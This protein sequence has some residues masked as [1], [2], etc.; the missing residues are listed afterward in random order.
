MSICY[1][2]NTTILTTPGL[3]YDSR[4]ITVEEARRYVA[5]RPMVS[6]V[7]HAATAAIAS[8]LL[9]VDVPES[10]AAIAMAVGDIAVCVKLRG[11][12]LEGV[13]LTREEVEGI[14]YDLV[15]LEARDPASRQ[16]F[17]TTMMDVAALLSYADDASPEGAEQ[18]PASRRRG[19]YPMQQHFVVRRPEAYGGDVR[20]RHAGVGHRRVGR[21]R[22]DSGGGPQT[23]RRS[24]RPR[25]VR[26]AQ[27]VPWG[28]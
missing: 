8:T 9:G 15:L 7:G 2:L 21:A 24:H 16:A 17:I 6:A 23:V 19:H 5:H 28:R 12:P 25:P 13:I 20:L 26:A 22:G 18:A 14:G 11:R 3:C 27:P 4:I 10:R 1:V